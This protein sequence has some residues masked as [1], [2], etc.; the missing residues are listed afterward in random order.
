[1]IPGA[2]AVCNMACIQSKLT[3]HAPQVE[4]ATLKW[5]GETVCEKFIFGTGGTLAELGSEAGMAIEAIESAE[6]FL[7]A[8]CAAAVTILGI[9]TLVLDFAVAWAARL[10]CGFVVG[11][12]MESIDG[13][14]IIKDLCGEAISGAFSP[15]NTHSSNPAFNPL[16]PPPGSGPLECATCTTQAP[17]V[18]KGCACPLNFADSYTQQCSAQLTY[19]NTGDSNTPA[20]IPIGCLNGNCCAGVLIDNNCFLPCDGSSY[21]IALL[22]EEWICKPTTE[23]CDTPVSTSSFI[24]TTQFSAPNCPSGQAITATFVASE[25]EN[26]ASCTEASLVLPGC[27]ANSVGSTFMACGTSLNDI[28]SQFHGQEAF[29]IQFFSDTVCTNLVEAT[30]VVANVC[31]A[32]VPGIYIKWFANSNNVADAVLYTDAACT[33]IS[34]QSLLGPGTQA[35]GVGE[36]SGNPPKVGGPCVAIPPSCDTVQNTGLPVLVGS[37][38]VIQI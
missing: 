15:D 30:F 18:P 22:N 33:T 11:K 17:D 10:G 21:G 5:L 1:M 9:E 26:Q 2:N 3:Q 23:S 38:Q 20:T 29:V 13:V 6:K 37:V 12:I 8:D 14:G 24:E 36:C 19:T 4:A 35:V 31:Y 28:E 32:T 16:S 25:I 7:V 27:Q 34:T